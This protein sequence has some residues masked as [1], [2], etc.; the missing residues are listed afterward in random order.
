MISLF[1]NYC[2]AICAAKIRLTAAVAQL[3]REDTSRDVL[4]AAFIRV[5]LRGEP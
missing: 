4:K 1:A 2:F 5:S 3:D